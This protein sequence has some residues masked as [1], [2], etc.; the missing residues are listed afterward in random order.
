MEDIIANILLEKQAVKIETKNPFTW[1]SGIKSPIYCDNRLLISYPDAVNTIVLGFKEIL[2]DMDFDIIAGTATA[3]IPWASFLSY[4]LD[5]PLIYIRKKP[6]EHGTKSQIEGVMK[7]NQK[8]VLI[9]DLISTGGSSISALQAI[10]N[11]GGIANTVLAI[12]SYGFP[13]A[14]KNFSE[15]EAQCKTLTN[16]PI[17]LDHLK[18]ITNDEKEDILNFSKDP[19]NWRN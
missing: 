9:E 1:T 11:E 5:K 6:K 14:Q 4:E 19:K 8:V 13:L 10:K 3:G 12:F 7:A 2:E 15:A 18:N 17:L 16:F